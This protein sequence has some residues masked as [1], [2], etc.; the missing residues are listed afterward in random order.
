MRMQT[1]TYSGNPPLRVPAEPG[2]LDREQSSDRDYH[3][4]RAGAS[5][6]E[7]RLLQMLRSHWH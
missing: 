2:D 4:Y 3:S 1:E 7:L 5:V 6:P